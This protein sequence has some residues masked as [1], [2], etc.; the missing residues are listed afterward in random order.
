[1]WSGRKAWKEEQGISAAWSL[2]SAMAPAAKPEIEDDD[3]NPPALDE[4]DI[5]L[6]KTYV[7]RDRSS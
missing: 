1:V 3:K 2:P 4:D 5:A 7:S 6:L